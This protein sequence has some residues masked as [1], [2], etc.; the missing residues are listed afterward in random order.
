MAKWIYKEDA[1]SEWWEHSCGASI[2]DDTMIDLVESEAKYCPFCGEKCTYEYE[3]DEKDEEWESGEYEIEQK[4]KEPKPYGL[5]ADELIF[6]ED[7]FMNIDAEDVALGEWISV[8]ERLPNMHQKVVGVCKNIDNRPVYAVVER[9]YYKDGWAWY[10]TII[11]I[12]PKTI[13]K[14]T[15]IPKY[16]E[17][18]SK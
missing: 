8:E 9:D 18:S 6:D 17:G 11:R 15:S 10:S 14:W 13:I 7:A 1:W 16:E 2:T 4:P 3:D 12:E 5:K